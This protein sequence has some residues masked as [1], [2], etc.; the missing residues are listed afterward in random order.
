[1]IRIFRIAAAL[2]LAGTAG[3]GD[4]K[5]ALQ[6]KDAG[7]PSVSLYSKSFDWLEEPAEKILKAPKFKT[8][9]RWGAIVLEAG[10]D[11]SIAVAVDDAGAGEAL[12]WVDANNDEDLT[13]DGEPA[14]EY[15][16]ESKSVGGTFKVLVDYGKA[17]YTYSMYVY[18]FRTSEKTFTAYRSQTWWEGTAALGGA[19]VRFGIVDQDN[20]AL[21]DDLEKLAIVF[22]FNRDGTL[23]GAQDS[24]EFYGGEEPFAWGGK[25][26]RVKSVSPAGDEVV[27][28]ELAEAPP[29]KPPLGPGAP[30]PD[31][32]GTD[33]EG[34]EVS[35]A[36]LAG[37]VVLLHFW[38]YQS[39][40][41]SLALDAHQKAWKA[42][43]DRGY[44]ILGVCLDSEK[45][46]AAEFAKDHDMTW[47]IVYDGKILAGPIAKLYRTYTYPRG[48][49]IDADG[50]IRENHAA[51][52]SLEK[53]VGELLGDA[54]AEPLVA[55]KPEDVAAFL[56]K[57]ER[58]DWWL[59][60][61]QRKAEQDD[62]D[63][64]LYMVMEANESRVGIV[65][66][67]TFGWSFALHVD[68]ATWSVVRIV[69][70]WVDWNS[71]KESFT[72]APE[73]ERTC[74]VEGAPSMVMF[75]QYP[76][77]DAV[78]H[79]FPAGAEG[80]L[81]AF[82]EQSASP[83]TSETSP[84][85]CETFVDANGR[86]VAK[87]KTMLE[88]RTLRVKQ[89]WEKGLPFPRRVTY[90]NSV[91]GSRGFLALCRSGKKASQVFPAT[92]HGY[93]I[94]G[95]ETNTDDLPAYR[96]PSRNLVGED[97]VAAACAKLAPGKA[98]PPLDIRGEAYWHRGDILKVYWQLRAIPKALSGPAK[99]QSEKTVEIPL[100]GVFTI[101]CVDL[102]RVGE[103][104]LVF[105][106]AY[107]EDTR[108][109][110]YD[111]SY[112]GIGQQ[113]K[114][115]ADMMSGSVP[116]HFSNPE[117][118]ID[119][120]DPKKTRWDRVSYIR[121]RRYGGFTFN[122]TAAN[123]RQATNWILAL[124]RDDMS[125]RAAYG[126]HL[127]NALRSGEFGVAVDA[128][129]Q[130]PAFVRQ[131]LQ[132]V[133]PTDW[134]LVQAFAGLKAGASKGNVL[135]VSPL[136]GGFFRHELLKDEEAVTQLVKSDKFFTLFSELLAKR[137]PPPEE[138]K[139]KKK[140]QAKV[141]LTEGDVARLEGGF[142]NGDFSGIVRRLED[143]KA[144]RDVMVFRTTNGPGLWVYQGYDA[145]YPWW[146][147]CLVLHW[148][149][150][151]L[152][153]LRMYVPVG[154]GGS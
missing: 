24:N 111:T 89:T 23:E 104:D 96:V 27:F 114:T 49:L 48:Y 42:Y 32:T 134:M 69:P 36:S 26:W 13:N 63:F 144:K 131:S 55:A 85:A 132:L 105:L 34:N 58:G 115:I 12:L 10:T 109:F 65:V 16:K 110:S 92:A 79:T 100:S 145:T 45:D 113:A 88:G 138:R 1:M 33:A 50:I 87:Y 5:V 90:S 9:P 150:G 20:D 80:V 75:R 136:Q 102:R 77:L 147:E 103:E 81:S 128:F 56:P 30:A 66:S 84:L 73:R 133:R 154:H 37:K 29:A 57:V 35:L 95:I 123:A 122:T 6:H 38:S 152:A 74:A 59:V 76:L 64:L 94:L 54:D 137:T 151:Y 120:Q 124:R 4:V 61:H 11:K 93:R 70:T 60:Y 143:G 117:Y 62:G 86:L 101:E 43:K 44:T 18:W 14:K 28:E 91:S 17:K 142:A 149:D 22:D 15:S 129:A 46:K 8:K 119:T 68:R 21:H 140:R 7:G 51:P 148:K 121:N 53:A 106:W 118:W 52:A 71:E 116:S 82:T 112:G 67:S 40:D 41:V 19:E 25:G 72:L 99:P 125:L 3:A 146:K 39:A 108:D 47:P 126:F 31:F 78:F 107:G 127:D 141:S 83:T 98:S 135:S 97:A 130:G 2:A 139:G 153:R